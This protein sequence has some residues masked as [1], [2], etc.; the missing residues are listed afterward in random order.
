MIITVFIYILLLFINMLCVFKKKN[1]KLVL[2]L[3][4][5]FLIILMGG[6][7]KNPDYENYYSYYYYGY[8]PSSMEKG[9]IGLSMIF[10]KIGVPYIAFTTILM[11]M[12]GGIVIWV[13]QK[14][15][16]NLHLI[17]LFYMLFQIY[18][19]YVQIRCTI[20]I[21]LFILALYFNAEKRKKSFLIAMIFSTLFHKMMIVYFAL[22]IV[23][24]KYKF[25]ETLLSFVFAIELLFC[26]IIFWNGNQLPFLSFF[27]SVLPIDIGKFEKYFTT[28]T[29]LSFVLSFFLQ[30]SNMFLT[31]FLKKTI[32]SNA[33]NY[34][35]EKK[36]R[37]IRFAEMIWISVLLTS[38]ALPLSM[39]H[40]EFT[41]CIRVGNI[42]VYFLAGILLYLA[43]D[44]KGKFY[45]AI[46]NK[47]K[48]NMWVYVGLIILNAIVW[49]IFYTPYNI[50]VDLLMY[51]GILPWY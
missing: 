16:A 15:S 41:R 37:I 5:F 50:N 9:Y 20:A 44:V 17:T 48:I 46:P 2:V 21:A 27:S 6:N 11:F 13:G 24:K 51:N 38:Y 47:Y 19:D 40:E 28:S 49:Y 26:I 14:V 30:F 25:F 12:A 36:Q 7:I 34:S 22:F 42:L 33:D 3:T 39:L 43:Q 18:Y 32:I 4:F 45:I 8:Y 29:S 31:F 10:S 1:N 35:K 23:G